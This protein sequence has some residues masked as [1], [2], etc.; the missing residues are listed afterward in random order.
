MTLMQLPGYGE[1]LLYREFTPKSNLNIHEELKKRKVRN[2]AQP[3][4]K[5]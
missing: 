3:C 4:V 2:D 5:I 1:M